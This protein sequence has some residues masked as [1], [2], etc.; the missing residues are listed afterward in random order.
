M[1]LTRIRLKIC[2]K[3]MI[4][5]KS[6]FRYMKCVCDYECAEVEDENFNVFLTR[7]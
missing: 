2:L 6:K 4:M 7:G 5:N 3:R 1:G